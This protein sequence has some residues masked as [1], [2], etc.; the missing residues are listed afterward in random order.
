VSPRSHIVN[1]ST[2]SNKDKSTDSYRPLP[3]LVKNVQSICIDDL[4]VKLVKMLDT[5]DDRLFDM[6]ENR[7][8]NTQFDAMRLLRL[9][10]EGLINGFKQELDNNFK[11]TLGKKDGVEINTDNVESLSF[12]NIALVKDD[13]LEEDIATDAMVNKGKTKNQG[14]IENIRTRLD[15]LVTYQSVDEIT[16]PF[17]PAYICE[18]F[19]QASQQ[20]LDLDIASLLVIYKLFDRSVID[21]LDSLYQKVNQFFIDKGILPELKHIIRKKHSSSDNSA[22]SLSSNPLDVIAEM[23]I[24]QHAEQVQEGSTENL[25]NGGTNSNTGANN[26][27]DA[28][29]QL[30][31]Q[32]RGAAHSR[33]NTSQPTAASSQNSAVNAG[34]VSAQTGKSQPIETQ[35][36][37]Q[38]LSSIQVSQAPQT[39]TNGQVQ[40][41]NLRETIGAQIPNFVSVGGQVGFGQFNED[42]ID[43]I[44]M[45]FD[46]ILE[47][48]NLK[49]EIKS[50]IARLQIPMLKV[51][52]VDKT[53]FSNKRHPARTLLNELAY[54]G[55]SWD[56][57]D[58]T[59]ESMFEKISSVSDKVINNFESDVN[60]FDD[61]LTDFLDFKE[62]NE[63][64][65]KIFERRTRE[66]E[67]GKAKSESARNEVNRALKK[68]CKNKLVP[69]VV[70][71][72]LK[73]V[74]SHV[75][76]L[77]RLKDNE[78]GWQ[79]RVRIA[80]LLVWSVQPIS[81]AKRLDKL[82]SRVPL[83]VKNLRKGMTLIS[84][85]PIESSTLFDQLERCHLD[86][87]GEAKHK[88]NQASK[89][90]ILRLPAIDVSK[91]PS[92]TQTENQEY[93]EHQ[94]VGDSSVDN[95]LIED[96]AFTGMSVEELQ[97]E[98]IGF[99]KAETGEVYQS[100]VNEPVEVDIETMQTVQQLRAGS[101]LELKI[102]N[103]YR[104]TKLAAI[105][106]S[107]GKYIFVN[108]NGMKMAEFLTEELCQ[109]FQL[110]NIKILDDEALFDRAL[111]SVI[112]NLRTMKKQA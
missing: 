110:G 6:A 81:D 101:W 63:Q 13:D 67:E 104:R 57:K 90:E 72:L 92:M 99:S 53:F 18:A 56:E 36:L 70:K 12:E 77:E 58:H 79:K 109:Y 105:I 31:S 45:L 15:T 74:W 89:E 22:S 103:E 46:F 52:L 91:K 64:R 14:A 10:R 30:M 3:V 102:D 112:S 80:E 76:L 17:E 5:A 19:R 20:T 38:A 21:E 25:D 23:Q 85:S 93:Q 42:M 86:I 54:A 49:P 51:G 47:D 34:G 43:I 60:I 68:A 84:F 48:K 97:I 7:Y 8:N 24:N 75:M 108:R 106:A 111:E 26:V 69:D 4:E 96:I 94:V 44:S 59:A 35:D 55:L 83:L 71:S 98:D 41:V 62:K 78:E 27:F 50:I 66:A 73:N 39:E 87:V 37:L 40:P 82:T 29:Q 1:L 33:V 32:N 95:I 107:T 88:I 61:L 65:A 28:I 16:N 2:K 11:R 9:K 100:K